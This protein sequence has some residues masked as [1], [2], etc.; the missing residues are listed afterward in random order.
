MQP[1]DPKKSSRAVD[2]LIMPMKLMALNLIHNCKMQDID[3]LVTCTYRCPTD[4]DLLYAQGRT[5][6]GH[7]VT[8][9]RAGDSLHQYRVAL[10]VVPLRNGKPVW[11]TAGDDGALWQKIGE[12]GKSAGLE[13]AGDWVHFKE[14]PHFQFTGGLT[15]AD[16]KAGKLPEALVGKAA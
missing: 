2:D 7:I 13:W 15:L 4:Q 11:S 14:Y 10:D 5:T 1:F 8:N 3:L 16:F 12:I 6:P 9:A